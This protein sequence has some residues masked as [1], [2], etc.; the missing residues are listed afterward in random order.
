MKEQFDKCEF[1]HS[2]K[3]SDK[4]L[5]TNEFDTTKNPK[6][7]LNWKGPAEIIDVNDTKA[8]V[9]FKK[10]AKCFKIKTFLRKHQKF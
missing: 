2:F 7:V 5:N 9:K 1:P 4:V 6:L 3:I 8:K 10:S